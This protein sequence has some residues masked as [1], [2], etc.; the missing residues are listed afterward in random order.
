MRDASGLSEV[1]KDG[2]EGALR[3]VV[4]QEEGLGVTVAVPKAVSV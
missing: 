3:E 2:V 1:R 4:P